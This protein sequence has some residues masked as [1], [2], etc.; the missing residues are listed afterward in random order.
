MTIKIIVSPAYRDI[1]NQIV[2]IINQPRPQG[3]VLR[4]AR[5]L[6]VRCRIGDHD[7]V[8]KRYGTPFFFNRIN[9]TFFR[10]SKPK[11]AYL[12]AR[13][14]A[15]M[16]YSTPE[17]VAYA[18]H[19]SNGLYD[20]GVFVCPYCP[21]PTVSSAVADTESVPKQLLD[22]LAAFTAKMHHDGIYFY[23]YNLGNILYHRDSETGKYEF[24]LIDC[25]RINFYNKPISFHKCVRVLYCLNFSPE[26][27]IYFMC[28][29]A[30]Y[31][32]VNW[33]IVSGA[34][35]LKQELSLTR[36]IKHRIKHKLGLDGSARKCD[37]DVATKA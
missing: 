8:V 21:D 14:L 19:R 7:M 13:R 12:N 32:N 28:R 22:D 2:E 31:R 4:D 20:W 23:D 1:E 6:I 33:K 9:Y 5:N 27:Y 30:E 29:Y 36:R 18:A 35:L 3:E 34:V 15:A 37:A 11:R 17:A 10:A 26:Q 16:G 24:T 25:N